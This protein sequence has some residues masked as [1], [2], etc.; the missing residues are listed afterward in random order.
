MTPE[1]LWE[2]FTAVHPEAANAKYE[3]WAFCGGG[4]A[5]DEL[6]ELVHRGLKTA[7]ASLKPIYDL[8]NEPIPAVGD[9]S[10]ILDSAGDAHCVL[11]VSKI[12][13]RPFKDVTPEHAFKE[14]EDGR[15]LEEW[16]EVHRRVF[17]M[18]L[19]EAGNDLRFS[20]DM[21]VVCEEFELL[22]SIDK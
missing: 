1:K 8:E 15:T 11:R 6:L 22:F 4:P 9:Y 2:Q 10:V 18:E 17:T 21:D 7:T 19:E 12:T 16:R 14:G 13:L 20:D 3:A 5:A